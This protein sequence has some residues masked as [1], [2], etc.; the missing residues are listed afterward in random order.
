MIGGM[1]GESRSESKRH[2]RRRAAAAGDVEESIVWPH[3]VEGGKHARSLQ[4]FL[5]DLRES[6]PHGN[7]E[8]FLDDVFVMHLLAFFNPSIRSLRTFEDA[9]KTRQVQGLLSKDGRISRSTLSDFHQF[10]DPSRLTPIIT[11]LRS[12][13]DEKYRG[14]QLPADLQQL[15]QEIL[16]VDGTF[17]T[18]AADVAWAVAYRNQT[19]TKHKARVDVHVNVSTWLPEVIAVP[20]PGEGEAQ[21][22]SHEVKAGAIHL[23][24]RG[25]NSFD[26]LKTHYQTTNDELEPLADFVMRA[27]LSQPIFEPTETRDCSGQEQVVSDRIGRLTGSKNKVA[28]PVAIREVVLKSPGEDGGIIRILTSLLDVPADVIGLLYRYRWQVELFFRWLK[29]YAC[30][31]HLISHS[32]QGAQ[33]QFYV[34]MIGVLLMYLHTGGR[35][36]KY[37]VAMLQLVASGAATLEE[38]M[39]IIRE[40]ERTCQLERERKARKRAEKSTTNK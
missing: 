23:Y 19:T 24:D 30:F 18:A 34:V 9:S 1:P 7:R 35:P 13:I 5:D 32:A 16:A 38:V 10:A 37:A 25:Y 22:A 27:K 4:S 6:D 17:F 2:K 21:H 40:R 8:L 39:P 26:L 11:H 14:K 29:S 36:S 31:D 12:L 3:Q 33:F 15:G 20:D 28:P